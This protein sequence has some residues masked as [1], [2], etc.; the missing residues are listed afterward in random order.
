V[1]HERPSKATS[2]GERGLASRWAVKTAEV[3]EVLEAAEAHHNLRAKALDLTSGGV[4]AT[5]T[6]T[7]NNNNN[8]K[9][10][11][12]L[13]LGYAY[14]V[15]CGKMSATVSTE[16][17]G[18]KA[19]PVERRTPE[20]ESLSVD[21]AASKDADPFRAELLGDCWRILAEIA[22]RGV[23]RLPWQKVRPSLSLLLEERLREYGSP[24]ESSESMALSRLLSGFEEYPFT[25]QRI[26]EILMVP[27][28]CYNKLDRLAWALEKCLMVTETVR[29]A[30][31]AAG[32]GEGALPSKRDLERE[33]GEMRRAAVRAVG[34]LGKRPADRGEGGTSR[35][36]AATTSEE[37][38]SGEVSGPLE[39]LPGSVFAGKPYVSMY[40][41]AGECKARGNGETTE[42]ILEMKEAVELSASAIKP[43]TV[44]LP[45]GGQGAHGSAFLEANVM[46]E[47]PQKK[48]RVDP[49]SGVL[50]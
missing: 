9:T 41:G 31:Q 45:A 36:A 48:A 23:L 5:H 18:T 11:L 16:V 21:L 20:S 46:V 4:L 39:L 8:N 22:T 19:V 30:D 12:V 28:A 26:C 49:E 29:P 27:G 1:L 17:L 44:A 34:G 6:H 43:E 13:E 32:S 14:G 33:V 40:G 7:H 50:E 42:D 24:R 3:A 38:C 2:P 15:W 10:S 25:I 35:A 47:S 37:A